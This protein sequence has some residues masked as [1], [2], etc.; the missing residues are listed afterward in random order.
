MSV[1]S[2]SQ[3]PQNLKEMLSISEIG[4]HKTRQLGKKSHTV[5]RALVEEGQGFVVSFIEQCI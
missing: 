4:S 2:F 3:F 1:E 5:V